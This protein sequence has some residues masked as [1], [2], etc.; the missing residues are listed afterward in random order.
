[1]IP[2]VVYPK[3]AIMDNKTFYSVLFI[4]RCIGT[5]STVLVL[6]FAEAGFGIIPVFDVYRQGDP[7]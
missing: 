4:I 1:M 5:M 2:L 6:T 7:Q 3:E